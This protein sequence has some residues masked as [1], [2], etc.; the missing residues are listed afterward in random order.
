MALGLLRS[1][2]DSPGLAVPAKYAALSVGRDVAGAP[3]H[4]D[5]PLFVEWIYDATR[6]KNLSRKI[7]FGD[8]FFKL[9]QLALQTADLESALGEHID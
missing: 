7:S 1:P 2:P 3:D 4:Q 6:L 9:G 5:R 8:Q